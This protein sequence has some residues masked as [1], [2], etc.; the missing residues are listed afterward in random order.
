MVDDRNKYFSRSTTSAN[1]N[2]ISGVF[3][4]RLG[5]HDRCTKTLTQEIRPRN[6]KRQATLNGAQSE[7]ANTVHYYSTHGTLQNIIITS[8]GY[9]G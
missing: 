9:F 5:V 4:E 3:L 7:Q 6:V 2:E 8:Q 1:V